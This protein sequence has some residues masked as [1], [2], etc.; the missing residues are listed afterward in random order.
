MYIDAACPFY[1]DNF[2]FPIDMPRNDFVFCSIIRGDTL[3]YN[4]S[5]V[6][7]IRGVNK[8]CF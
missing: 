7:S 6:V 8:N 3:I 4:D 2:S 1:S 5:Q